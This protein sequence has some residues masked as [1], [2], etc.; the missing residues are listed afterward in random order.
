MITA[1]SNDVNEEC[2]TV[3]G[4]STTGGIVAEDCSSS[5][6]ALC[7]QASKYCFV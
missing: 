6:H 2:A 3:S 4:N 1:L 7:E 5:F